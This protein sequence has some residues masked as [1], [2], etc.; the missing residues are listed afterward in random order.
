VSGEPQDPPTGS[1]ADQPDPL[2]TA[3]SIPLPATFQAAYIDPSY[4]HREGAEPLDAD[5]TVA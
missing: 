4:Q 3:K 2:F 5:G 1:A